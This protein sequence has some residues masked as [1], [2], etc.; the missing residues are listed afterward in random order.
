MIGHKIKMVKEISVNISK[1]IGRVGEFGSDMVSA[2]ITMS[3]EDDVKVKEAYSDAW[4]IVKEEIEEQETLLSDK[5]DMKEV[6]DSI[7]VSP[8]TAPTPPTAIPVQKPIADPIM[9][10]TTPVCPIHG[11]TV[12]YRP[13]GISKAGKPY[14]GFYSCTFRMPDGT[15][16]KEKFQ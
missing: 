10:A 4:G 1:K 5:R 8:V 12:V 13:S 3:I 6:A 2:S 16:C 11:N 15:F 7:P 9:T 14:P